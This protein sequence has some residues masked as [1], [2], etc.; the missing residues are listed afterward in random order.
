V[1]N[2]RRIGVLL[3][4]AVAGCGSSTKSSTPTAEPTVAASTT[5]ETTTAPTT[6]PSTTATT[7]STTTT[8]APAPKGSAT[9]DLTFVGDVGLDGAS[10]NP[11]VTCNAP[12][13]DGSVVIRV[14]AHP[15]APED[16]F[17]ITLSEGRITVRVGSGSGVDATLRTFQGDG[18]TDIDAATGAQIDT[19]L[20]ETTR[21]TDNRGTIG[22]IFAVS[23]S[24]DCGDQTVGTST[25]TY[26]GE[27]LDGAVSGGPDPFRVECN[28]SP[29]GDF[30]SLV[31]LVSVG[32]VKAL[33]F[34]T[35]EADSI[36]AF[37]TLAGPPL[38]QHQYALNAT[39][40]STLT[41]TGAHVVGDIV[42][43]S[44]ASGEAHTLH[45]D[46]DVTCGAT[47]HR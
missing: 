6:V 33:I 45:I 37:E 3:I 16:L 41:G 19:G 10:S 11:V 4:F 24:V 7:E 20:F 15:A 8:L 31:G 39:G 47:V 40:A 21:P 5:A 27:T 12:N 25:V 2:L 36:N 42:E 30:V 35:F 23:G 17:N 46:G 13:L 43:Q 34:T 1:A 29:K 9:A 38:V 26:S 14:S 22:T 18:V 28:T 32:E 44:P